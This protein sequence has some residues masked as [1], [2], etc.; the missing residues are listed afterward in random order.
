[1]CRTK[2]TAHAAPGY[3]VSAI[4]QRPFQVH[5]A[6]DRPDESF[7]QVKYQDYWYWIDNSDIASKRV[8]TLMLFITT[9][10]NRA[11]E[12]NAPVLTIPTQ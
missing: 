7:A 2:K 1:M 12:Q 6:K 10:T 4:S 11:N 3:D 9:L 8:F 5:S